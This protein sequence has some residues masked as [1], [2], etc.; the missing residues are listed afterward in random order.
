[1]QKNSFTLAMQMF[2]VV[3]HG[4]TMYLIHVGSEGAASDSGA[5]SERRESQETGSDDQPKKKMRVRHIY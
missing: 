1:M 5:V 4:S 2:I 3:N